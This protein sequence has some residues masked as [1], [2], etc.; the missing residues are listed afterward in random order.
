MTRFMHPLLLLI[1]KFTDKEL[2]KLLEYLLAENRC[3]RSKLPKRIEVTPAERAN[4]VKL[5]KPLS[6]KLK[7]IISIVPYRTFFRWANETNPTI[8][9]VRLEDRDKVPPDLSDAVPLGKITCHEYLGGLLKHYE[10]KAA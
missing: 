4:L 5:G 8:G 3:L 10:R 7:D 9:D 6:T 1:S 2:A